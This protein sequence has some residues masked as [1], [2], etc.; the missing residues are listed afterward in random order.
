MFLLL[1]VG[2]KGGGVSDAEM[3][4]SGAVAFSLLS[5]RSDG[6]LKLTPDILFAQFGNHCSV[7]VFL[8]TFV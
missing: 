4:G 1:V 3:L 2:Q 7:N 8:R 5:F 6:Y